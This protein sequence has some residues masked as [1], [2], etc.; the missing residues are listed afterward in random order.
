MKACVLKITI[1]SLF[2]GSNEFEK[3]RNVDYRGKLTQNDGVLNFRVKRDGNIKK[4][5]RNY[6]S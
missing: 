3:V 4:N 1:N 2:Y 5:Y 6:K